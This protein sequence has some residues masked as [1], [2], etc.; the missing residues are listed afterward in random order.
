MAWT[1]VII[2]SV[3]GA[4]L[5]SVLPMD[6]CLAPLGVAFPLAIIARNGG[7]R[8]VSRIAVSLL[9]MSLVFVAAWA[10]PLKHDDRTHLTFASRCV[11]MD[12]VLKELGTK[13]DRS[14]ELCFSSASP[15][16][17]EVLARLEESG[18]KLRFGYCGTG[19][20]LLFGPYPMRVMRRE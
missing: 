18:I 16:R 20:T 3:L 14:E 8:L 13:P 5:A 7:P 12:E 2:W 11:P 17:R 1:R 19:A 10:A 6:F 15:T 9:V 4:A